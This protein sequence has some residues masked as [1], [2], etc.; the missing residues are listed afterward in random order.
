VFYQFS[1]ER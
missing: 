1:Q